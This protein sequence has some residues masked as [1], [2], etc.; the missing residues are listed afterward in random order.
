MKSLYTREE[1]YNEAGI[2]V[3]NE[4][5]EAIEPI[6]RKWADKG[7]RTSDIENIAI[8]DITYLTALIRL[9]VRIKKRKKGRLE[10]QSE[11]SQDGGNR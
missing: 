3:S 9:K 8:Q 10:I 2:K 1:I 6:L 7:Y 5:Q 4:I 11:K